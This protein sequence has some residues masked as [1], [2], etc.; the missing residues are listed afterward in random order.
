MTLEELARAFVELYEDSG[1]SGIADEMTIDQ[2]DTGNKH[3]DTYVACQ[4]LL[5]TKG[6]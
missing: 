2:I 1:L 5:G 4:K 6:F 3:W